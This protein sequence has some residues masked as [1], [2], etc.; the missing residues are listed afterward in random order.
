MVLLDWPTCGWFRLTP[1]GAE[2]KTGVRHIYGEEASLQG[3]QVNMSLP[4]VQVICNNRESDAAIKIG[5]LAPM[6]F[7]DFY[8]HKG[9]GF[10]SAQAIEALARSLPSLPSMAAPGA[11]SPATSDTSSSAAPVG[12][13]VPQHLLER[14]NASAEGS[15]DA[16]APADPST[17]EVEVSASE[18]AEGALAIQPPPPPPEEESELPAVVS[19]V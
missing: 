11:P 13:I 9:S 5:R 12:C 10:P 17:P 15:V 14:F 19:D 2:V 8:K 4:E 1:D 3:I 16:A 6:K 7:M 18:P